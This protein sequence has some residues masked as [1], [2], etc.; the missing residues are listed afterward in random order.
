VKR[1]LRDAGSDTRVETITRRIREQTG[2][3][4]SRAVLIARTET[5]SLNANL[6]QARHEAAG[7]TEF[8]WSTSRD[9]R[10]RES[11][12]EL[13]GKRFAYDALPEI[14]GEGRHLPGAFP[15]CRC[16]AV[17]VVP[18]LDD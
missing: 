3:T 6:T 8:V 15:R 2:A 18:G 9:E 13:D 12:R 17:P 10:V 4:E 5:T 7:I 11:H 14:E 1:V 16:V